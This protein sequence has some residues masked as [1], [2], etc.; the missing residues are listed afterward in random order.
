MLLIWMIVNSLARQ[1]T[2]RVPA[3]APTSKS[4]L[5]L[6][7]SATLFFEMRSQIVPGG[8]TSIG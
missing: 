5:D 6:C 4:D 8:F 3:L 7:D 1:A 2:H